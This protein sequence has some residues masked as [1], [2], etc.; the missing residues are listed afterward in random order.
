MMWPVRQA[1]GTRVTR[2]STSSSSESM[3]PFTN[4]S[5]PFRFNQRDFMRTQLLLSLCVGSLAMGSVMAAP[6]PADT[7]IAWNLNAAQIAASCKQALDRAQQGIDAIDAR[8]AT[9]A[10][11]AL[12]EDVERT[13]ADTTDALA[14][15]TLLMNVSVDK[16]IRDSSSHCVDD[17]SAFSVKL[18]ADP[19]LYGIAQGAV[20]S[21]PT[22][23]ERRLAQLY[24]EAGRRTGAGLSPQQRA[25]VTEL[26]VQLTKLQTQ[27]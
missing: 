14:A 5:F 22:A 2:R 3:T 4:C 26:F 6:L 25:K 12:L 11:P 18:N 7:G 21:A 23:A 24:V 10:N 8:G 13:T 16:G 17:V 15:Q 27:F 1:S 19:V 9:G 20:K